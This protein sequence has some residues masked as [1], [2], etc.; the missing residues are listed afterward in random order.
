MSQKKNDKSDAAKIT[1][2]ARDMPE[3]AW[4]RVSVPTVQEQAERASITSYVFF[5][6]EETQLTNR[7][8]A[9]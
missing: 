2:I 6:Q 1:C 9:L 8:Y 7:L 5:K 4:P 3:E